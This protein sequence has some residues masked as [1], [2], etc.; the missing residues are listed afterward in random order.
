MLQWI[1][2]NFYSKTQFDKVNK[3]YAHIKFYDHITHKIV[4]YLLNSFF[5]WIHLIITIHLI[6]I[7]RKKL[8]LYCE[9]VNINTYSIS[10]FTT[11]SQF[12]TIKY[13]NNLFQINTIVKNNSYIAIFVAIQ[14]V[15]KLCLIYINNL[16]NSLSTQFMS[17]K[18][19]VWVIQCSDSNH[20]RMTIALHRIYLFLNKV[21]VFTYYYIILNSCFCVTIFNFLHYF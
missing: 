20:S 16:L 11:V 8:F 5:W 21:Y 10:Q 14:P 7:I 19:Q 9:Y 6:I 1:L 4:G 12:T 13:R 3:F 18:K 17:K 2:Y 15:I